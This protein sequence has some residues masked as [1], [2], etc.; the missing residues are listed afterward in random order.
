MR[1]K[2]MMVSIEVERE[3]EKDPQYQ[4][5][6]N[7]KKELETLAEN[8]KGKMLRHRY[9]GTGHLLEA[10]PRM[11]HE[12]YREALE[13]LKKSMQEKREELRRENKDL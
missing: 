2:L 5:L 9:Y 8:Y 7:R 13:E 11:R 10:F 3:A 4:K 1:N 12:D 6:L